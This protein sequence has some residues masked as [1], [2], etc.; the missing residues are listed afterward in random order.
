MLRSFQWLSTYTCLVCIL[1]G[2][3]HWITTHQ[4]N[5]SITIFLMVQRITVRLVCPPLIFISTNQSRLPPLHKIFGVLFSHQISRYAYIVYA[6]PLLFVQ[7]TSRFF[8][9]CVRVCVMYEHLL[10]FT[11]FI[12]IIHLVMCAYILQCVAQRTKGGGLPLYRCINETLFKMKFFAF[13]STC[14]RILLG[15]NPR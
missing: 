14:T 7:H 1:Y 2:N 6:T 3:I 11:I 13:L 8:P 5:I 9:L 12:F 10:F 15:K 4:R